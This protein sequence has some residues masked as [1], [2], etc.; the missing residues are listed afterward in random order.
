MKRRWKMTKIDVLVAMLED[1]KNAISF[2]NA[3]TNGYKE[4]VQFAIDMIKIAEKAD[5][6][7]KELEEAC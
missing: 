1:H 4:G 7:F 3:Y 6:N 5:T 2:S